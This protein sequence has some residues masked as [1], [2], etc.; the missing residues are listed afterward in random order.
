MTVPRADVAKGVSAPLV[1]TA[2]TVCAAGST[3]VTCVKAR[4]TSLAGSV[5]VVILTPAIWPAA[6][7]VAKFDQEWS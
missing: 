1:P 5:S 7:A 2:A 4:R 3:P 6:S